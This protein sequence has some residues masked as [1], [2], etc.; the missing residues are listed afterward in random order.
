VPLLRPQQGQPLGQGLLEADFAG[1]A[2]VGE[3]FYLAHA[4]GAVG[5]PLQGNVGQLIEAFNLRK[6]GVEIENEVG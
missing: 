3:G 1:H 6:R 5:L 4:L 2:A